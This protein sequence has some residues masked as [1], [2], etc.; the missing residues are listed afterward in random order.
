MANDYTTKIEGLLYCVRNID[1]IV[2]C[3][4]IF[5]AVHTRKYIKRFTFP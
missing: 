4:S 2:Y 3:A 5:Q 1:Y